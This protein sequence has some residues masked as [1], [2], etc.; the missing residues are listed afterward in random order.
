LYFSILERE[1]SKLP[2]FDDVLRELCETDVHL[3]FASKLVATVNPDKPV[4][5]SHVDNVL[6]AHGIRF[7]T[8]YGRK[9]ERK[10]EQAIENYR[11]LVRTTCALVGHPGFAKLRGSFDKRFCEFRHFTDI[12]K[13]DAYMWWSVQ[14]S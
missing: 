2:V 8:Y 12:K 10:L 4:Y 1:K 3:S 11:L 13:L 14:G 9:T 7:G 5:D 6:A